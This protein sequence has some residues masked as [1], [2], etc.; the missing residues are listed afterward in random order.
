MYTPQPPDNFS[1]PHQTIMYGCTLH[2]G[3]HWH[4][5]CSLA[6]QSRRLGVRA[7]TALRA[8][9]RPAASSA[10]RLFQT[11][12]RLNYKVEVNK[13]SVEVPP[14]LPG[15]FKAQRPVL[16]EDLGADDV[17]RMSAI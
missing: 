15:P 11:A 17:E 9:A 6:H 3:Q 16:Y 8:V 12:S 1:P 13:D 2:D 4:V 14:N 5:V 10:P 7:F